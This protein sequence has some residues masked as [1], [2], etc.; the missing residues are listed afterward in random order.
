MVCLIMM[1]LMLLKITKG[2]L[3]SAVC[4]QLTCQP[5]NVCCTLVLPTK[6]R[7]HLDTFNATLFLQ[8]DCH[9]PQIS[10]S[11]QVYY[12][13]L[14]TVMWVFIVIDD[15]RDKSHWAN[16]EW[17]F[18]QSIVEDSI[19]YTLLFA[20]LC[21]VRSW[22]MTAF[23]GTL[24]GIIKLSKI[25]RLFPIPINSQSTILGENRAAVSEK[26]VKLRN[27][28]APLF[29]FVGTFLKCCQVIDFEY[30]ITAPGC[31]RKLNEISFDNKCSVNHSCCYMLRLWSSLQHSVSSE[32][33]DFKSSFWRGLFRLSGNTRDFRQQFSTHKIC[34]CCA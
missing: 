30:L 16:K 18:V 23:K 29:C 5:Q 31:E 4:F 7:D 10:A 24:K 3:D 8:F 20:S 22:D 32:D 15:H 12:M 14:A 13:I 27:C 17:C 9:C 11:F 21:S 2:A 33:R 1:F 6:C 25:E 34:F 28:S 26:T 19:L